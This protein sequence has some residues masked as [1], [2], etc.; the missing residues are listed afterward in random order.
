VANGYRAALDVIGAVLCL[1]GVAI[2]A[3]VVGMIA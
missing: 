1:V 3:K 2:L